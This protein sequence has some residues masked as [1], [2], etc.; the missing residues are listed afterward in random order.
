[1]ELTDTKPEP[2]TATPPPKP[3]MRLKIEPGQPM[4]F[5]S[6]ALPP[7]RHCAQSERTPP[8]VASPMAPSSISYRPAAYPE[9]PAVCIGVNQQSRSPVKGRAPVAQPT[10]GLFAFYL[11]PPKKPPPSDRDRYEKDLPTVQDRLASL[12][13]AEALGVRTLDEETYVTPRISFREKSMAH[14]VVISKEGKT[15]RVKGFAK[16]FEQF[17]DALSA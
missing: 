13:S 8:K 9:T 11:P 6:D 3:D 4:A 7:F 1:M 5:K 10:G 2:P 14:P 15:N 17:T 12:K 16:F